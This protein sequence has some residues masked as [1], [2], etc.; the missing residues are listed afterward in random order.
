MVVLRMNVEMNDLMEILT[1]ELDSIIL[2]LWK[3]TAKDG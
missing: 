2:H 3:I 1:G